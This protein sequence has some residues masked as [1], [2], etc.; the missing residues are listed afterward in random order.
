MNSFLHVWIAC[1]LAGC[2]GGVP[3]VN[4]APFPDH[5]TQPGSEFLSL[6]PAIIDRTLA[7]APQLTPLLVDVNS[8]VAGNR[9]LGGTKN[10]PRTV[11]LAIGRAFL[12]VPTSAAV[13][14]RSEYQYEVLHSGIHISLDRIARTHSGYEAVVTYRYTERRGV[15]SGIGM[16]QIAMEF[17]RNGDKWQ[18]V[19]ERVLGTT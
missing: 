1:F 17:V 7:R 8:F 2:A 19:S 4:S 9:V 13:T 10:D 3:S 18:V 14:R 12:D 15:S 6:V 16:A 5:D 11:G